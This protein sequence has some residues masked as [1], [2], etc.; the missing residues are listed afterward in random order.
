[1]KLS[2]HFNHPSAISRPASPPWPRRAAATVLEV[3]FATLVIVVG[4]IGIASIIPVAGRHALEAT[5]SNALPLGLA[6]SDSFIA[7]VIPT[8]SW[9]IAGP[10]QRFTLMSILHGGNG[11]AFGGCASWQFVS[12]RI[13]SLRQ[14]TLD[15]FQPILLAV[16]IKPPHFHTML[17][18]IR[19]SPTHASPRQLTRLPPI[20][21]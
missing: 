11:R 4:L 5:H 2:R 18:I 16:H 6:W 1:M 9:R 12:T 17:T 19:Q 14:S 21:E 15:Y 7:R 8:Q 10:V 20:L 13:P 3:L